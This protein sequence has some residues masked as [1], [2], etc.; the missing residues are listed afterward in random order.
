LFYWTQ[1][2]FHGKDNVKFILF[3]DGLGGTDSQKNLM[4]AI[5]WKNLI[6]KGEPEMNVQQ[7]NGVYCQLVEE[8][9]VEVDYELFLYTLFE[10]MDE[11]NGYNNY[12]KFFD[13]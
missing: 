1:V 3:D 4:M 8:R 10:N 13:C 5:D 12:T 9:E 7:L 2:S 6:Y 11:D